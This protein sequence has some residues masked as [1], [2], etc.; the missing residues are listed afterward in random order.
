MVSNTNN[1]QAAEVRRMLDLKLS[2]ASAVKA[3]S[4]KDRALTRLN[5]REAT[6][7]AAT[8]K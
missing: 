6:D 4:T 7:W 3:G 2:N 1:S 8:L 5:E